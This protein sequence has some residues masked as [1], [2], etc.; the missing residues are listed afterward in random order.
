[1]LVPYPLG[2]GLERLRSMGG[3]DAMKGHKQVIDGL[4]EVLTGELT[5]INQYFLHARMVKNWGYTK[6]ADKIWHE[7]IDEMKH[8]QTITDRIL[9]LEGL[10]NLQRLGKLKIGENT[11]EIMAADL[12]L[13]HIN[14]PKVR[15]AIEQCIAHHD[16]VT[17]ELL[18]HILEDE[19]EHVDWI[20]AQQQIIKDIG[21][22]NYLAQQ[23]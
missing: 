9:F 5:A 18:E 17:R 16:H 13:E 12:E 6:L 20:E 23:I 15:A 22:A 7:S 1:M 2:Y 8:A 19:E 14:I 3:E 10:P 21:I 4:N 11:E